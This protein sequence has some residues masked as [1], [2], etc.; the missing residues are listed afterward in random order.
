MGD[1]E[2]LFWFVAI[3]HT[4]IQKYIDD[5]QPYLDENHS[6]IIGIEKA[7]GV[8]TLTAGEHIHLAVKGISLDNYNKFH[9]NIHRKK[10]KL[11]LKAKDGYG[12]QVGRVKSKIR[13]ETKFMSYTLKDKN[14]IC[15]NMDLER[16]QQYIEK[17]Y[18]K[19]APWEQQIYDY[20]KLNHNPDIEE[21]KTKWYMTAPIVR[22]ILNFYLEHS[23]TYAVPASHLVN[24]IVK[25]YLLYECRAIDQL[26]SLYSVRF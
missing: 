15:K 1:T 24:K 25:K 9:D 26:E 14:Y 5:L 7:G 18:P 12:K 3:R 23:K 8:H 2:F 21:V 10:M 19:E 11:I 16:I 6:Y 20:I 22:L 13:D 4:E 17:S